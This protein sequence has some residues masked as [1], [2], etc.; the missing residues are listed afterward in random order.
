MGVHRF[1]IPSFHT[2]H[3][4]HTYRYRIVPHICDGVVLKRSEMALLLPATKLARPLQG[5]ETRPKHD[6][7]TNRA[8]G[9]QNGATDYEFKLSARRYI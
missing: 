7:D 4:Y 3:T 9:K 6:I 1:F 5:T 8:N 2:D